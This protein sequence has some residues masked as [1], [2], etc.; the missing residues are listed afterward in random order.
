MSYQNGYTSFQSDQILPGVSFLKADRRPC[1]VCQ[2][3]TGDCVGDVEES[4]IILADQAPE[5]K[6]LIRVKERITKEVWVTPLTQVTIVVADAGTYVT[7]ER[8][9]ELGII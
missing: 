2:H 1:P 8:A 3:P 7:V 6:N 4:H 5:G 9:K